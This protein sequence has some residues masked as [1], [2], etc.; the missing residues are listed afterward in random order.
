HFILDA[1]GVALASSTYDFA[2]RAV[3]AICGLAGSGEDAVIGMPIRVPPRAVALLNG[4]LIHGLD[5][6]DTHSG[7]VIHATSSVLPTVL[8]VGARLHARGR[9]A[10]AA[11]VLCV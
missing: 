6:D 4:I 8:A 10:V 1:V 5:F 11:H 3:T 7:G 2:H 9:E